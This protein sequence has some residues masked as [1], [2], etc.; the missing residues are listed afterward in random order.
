MKRIVII[1]GPNLN[2]LGTREPDK[3]GKDSLQKINDSLVN[4]SE[5]LDVQCEFFQSNVEGE[6]VSAIQNAAGADGVILNAAAYT[7][8][9]IAIRDAVAAIAA[10]V[11]E[12]HLSN[13]SA[14]EE[15]R[16]PSMIAPVCCGTIAGF[17]AKSYVLALWAL[18]KR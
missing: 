4:E 8:Y 12:V 1:N 9:S 15:F 16:Q 7:H 17:G 3:Y 18:A 10:P 11:V 14:R 6:L 13:V 2:L 5:K